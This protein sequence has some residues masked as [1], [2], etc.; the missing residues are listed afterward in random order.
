VDAGFNLAHGQAVAG[1]GLGG[2]IGGI[3]A[4]TKWFGDGRDGEWVDER[5]ETVD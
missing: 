1:D 3:G 5:L 4:Q 2:M